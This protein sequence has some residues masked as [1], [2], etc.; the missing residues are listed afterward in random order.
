M[1]GEEKKRLGQ[2]PPT[3]TSEEESRPAAGAALPGWQVAKNGRGACLREG[4][5][6]HG[7]QRR[8]GEKERVGS[9][10]REGISR[11][12]RAPQPNQNW[13]KTAQ[14][15]ESGTAGQEEPHCRPANLQGLR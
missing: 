5:R 10:A 2:E 3:V 8:L 4:K 6:E 7:R 11:R 14:F 13:L 12:K 1:E 15:S 9:R